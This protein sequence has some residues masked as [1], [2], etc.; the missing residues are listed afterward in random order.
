MYLLRTYVNGH[1]EVRGQMLDVV[2]SFHLVNFGIKFKLS[3]LAP[4]TLSL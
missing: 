1:V 3:G 2:L 4:S